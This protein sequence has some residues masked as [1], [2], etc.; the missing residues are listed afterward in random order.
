MRSNI[1]RPQ[2]FD[3][4]VLDALEVRVEYL[5]EARPQQQG[6]AVEE[7]VQHGDA[8]ALHHEAQ[9][10]RHLWRYDIDQ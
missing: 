8:P 7:S 9:Q 4:G 3:I 2:L 10:V 5:F 1:H 6:D